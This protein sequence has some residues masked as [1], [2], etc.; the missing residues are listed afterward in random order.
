MIVRNERAET[1]QLGDKAVRKVLGTGGSLM[2]VEITLKRV[3][4]AKCTLIRSTN[5]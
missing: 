5:R 4:S 1:K 2:M 3:G